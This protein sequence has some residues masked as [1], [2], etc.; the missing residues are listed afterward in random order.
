MQE[1]TIG[2]IVKLV[3]GGPSMTVVGT[4]GEFVRC[5]WFDSHNQVQTEAFH[6]GVIV[7]DDKR[8]SPATDFA[9]RS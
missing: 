3:S 2:T 6:A 1:F 7:V 5:T 4:G 8:T 9:R